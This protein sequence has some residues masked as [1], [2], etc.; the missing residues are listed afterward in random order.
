MDFPRTKELNGVPVIRNATAIII[1]DPLNNKAALVVF[2]REGGCVMQTSLD[3]PG[4]L[5]T[6]TLTDLKEYF[7]G[8][9]M[10]AEATIATR[11]LEELDRITAQ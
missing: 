7:K 3:D 8:P 11:V 9:A 6:V 2:D 4:N 10:V 1:Y 5:R